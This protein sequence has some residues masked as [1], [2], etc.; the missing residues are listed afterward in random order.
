MAGQN[1]IPIPQKTRRIVIWT[2]LS[3][4]ALIGSTSWLAKIGF[5]ISMWFVCGTYRRFR[6]TPKSLK[7][8][9]T[10]GF[11]DLPASSHPLR[12]FARIEVKYHSSTSYGEL[13]LF[14]LPA[15]LFGWLLNSC[16]PWLGGNYQIWLTNGSDNRLLAWQ[17]NSQQAYEQNLEFLKSLTGMEI[18]F[19]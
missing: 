5:I 19:Q 12:R 15:L 13:I 9:W 14:G 17:G 1:L 11:W 16:F 3:S 7:H 8:R 10:V 4:L 18:V 2:C 6:A